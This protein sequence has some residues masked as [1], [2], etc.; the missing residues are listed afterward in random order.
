[1]SE[2]DED[3]LFFGAEPEDLAGD[4]KAE[5][6][7]WPKRYPRDL[8]STIEQGQIHQQGIMQLR[9]EVSSVVDVV[10]DAEQQL[11]AAQNVLK[12]R[13]LVVFGIAIGLLFILAAAVYWLQ[14]SQVLNPLRQL[15]DGF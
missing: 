1:M 13:L 6:R 12:Q 4:I 14:R 2:V 7:S 9:T 3:E 15:R 10:I 8:Q 5:I 11:R